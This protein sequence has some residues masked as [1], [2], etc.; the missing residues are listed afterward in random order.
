[1]AFRERLARDIRRYTPDVEPALRAFQRV[2][3]GNLARQLEPE[4]FRWLFLENP[5][6]P[7]EGPELW[8]CEKA[9]RIVGQQA[10]VAVRLSV[11]GAEVRASWAIDLMVEP[12]WR[13]KGVGPALTE[14]FVETVPVAIGVGITDSAYKAIVRA[15][16]I[17]LGTVPTF[18]RPLDPGRVLAWRTRGR[19]T[20]RGR[21]AGLLSAPARASAFL[22]GVRVR[23]TGYRLQ[24]IPR[25][26]DR[27]DRIWQAVRGEHE[28][29]VTRDLRALRWR[30]DEGPD[31]ERYE[32]FYLLRGLECVGY[33]V[34]RRGELL[35]SEVVFVIDL[36]CPRRHLGAMASLLA[37]RAAATSAAAVVLD[38]L[39][40][41]A[42]PILR[43]H[44]F[45]RV[46]RAS[47]RRFLA[48]TREHRE[49][50][51]DP[52]RW[53]VTRADS[54]WDHPNAVETG[55]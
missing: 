37:A 24:A 2:N 38:L 46:Q 7:S 12:E 30:F 17:D 39:E 32:R 26:D 21:L 8:V 41:R 13:L 40:A 36:L 49:L 45:L 28:V 15:G 51:S 27:V 54:D 18:V 34:L 16:W 6:T 9:G 22:D 31:R 4:R 33:V 52:A 10:G 48:Q 14:T 20:W 23:L 1:M 50:L 47:Q 53:F 35:G 11:H 44:G 43:R 55:E 29:L 5:A 42:G 19:R 25:F 3:F